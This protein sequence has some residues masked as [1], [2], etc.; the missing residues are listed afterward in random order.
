MTDQQL[1]DFRSYVELCERHRRALD[2]PDC[3]AAMADLLRPVLDEVD[4]VDH[5]RK[6]FRKL[7]DEL[8]ERT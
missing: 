8:L 2:G 4:E 5:Q 1:S 6:H 3:T 7:R